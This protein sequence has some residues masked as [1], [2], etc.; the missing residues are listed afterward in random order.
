MTV[1]HRT[2][3]LYILLTVSVSHAA[4]YAQTAQAPAQASAPARS[5]SEIGTASTGPV[6]VTRQTR[7]S[8]AL[9][10]NPLLGDP[11]SPLTE[12]VLVVPGKPMDPQAVGQ[13]VE[14]LSIM[15]RIIEKNALGESSTLGG[16]GEV[17]AY[18]FYRIYRRPAAGPGPFFPHVGQPKPMYL[19]GYGAVFFIQVDYPLLPP[20]PTPQEQQVNPQEDPVWAQTRRDLLEPQSPAALPREAGESA[21]APEP[22]SQEAVDTLKTQLIA[23]MKHATNIRALEPGDWVTFVVR[24][25]GA[26]DSGRT[27][28]TLRATKADAD[29]YAKG[30]LSQQQFEQRMQ[31][32]T[33]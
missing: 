1:L 24:G 21:Q 30:Q 28:M 26:T 31:I 20:P 5:A 12:S 11:A 4:L 18:T 22:Y 15:S 14:D 33:Y 6:S 7:Q 27:T 3:L 32:V 25:P 9:P 13:T 19:G 29:Q 8:L 17:S 23:A 10:Y 16:L 2:Q